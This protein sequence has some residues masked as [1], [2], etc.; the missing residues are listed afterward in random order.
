MIADRAKQLDFIST[1][2]PSEVDRKDVRS[3]YYGIPE[4]QQDKIQTITPLS[5]RWQ[6]R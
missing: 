6:I 1:R 3:N 2:L 5:F 4:R